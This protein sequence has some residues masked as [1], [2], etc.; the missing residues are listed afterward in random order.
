MK[1]SRNSLIAV[2]VTLVVALVFVLGYGQL[3]KPK[4][5]EGGASGTFVSTQTGFGGDV[6]V[7][8]TLENGTITDVKL[9]GDSE[10]PAVGGAALETLAENI[11]AA[12]S[13]E[14][15]LVSGATITS[16]AVQE[17]VKDALAQAGSASAGVSGT[18]TSTQT[19]FGGDVEVTLTI[20]NNVITDVALV[21]D[22]ETPAVGGAALETL[23]ENIKAANS[24][25]FD[26]VSGAT[27][28]S[29]AVQEGVKDAL[30]Q[31]GLE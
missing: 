31:A 25:E 19:G 15:D 30:T 27:I 18:F 17:G 9:V 14:F 16:N 5:T 3:T 21:G 29:N 4:T 23:A 10:T 28:T 8:L 26:V 13:A 24:S 20:E 6:E 2:V 1:E 12:N 22:S 7:T 11:K